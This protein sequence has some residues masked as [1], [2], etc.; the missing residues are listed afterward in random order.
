MRYFNQAGW[1]AIFNGTESLIGRSVAVE[2]WDETTGTALVVDP[3]RGAL[4]PVTD[5]PDFSHLERADQVL[6]AVPGEAGAP[7]GRTKASREHR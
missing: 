6:A 4:R 7:T 3:Q 5:Y 1:L 2:E